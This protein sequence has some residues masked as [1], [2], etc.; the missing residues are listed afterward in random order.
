VLDIHLEGRL[1]GVYSDDALGRS[2]RFTYDSAYT[3]D[4][5]ATPLSL[6]LPMSTQVHEGPAVSA[7]FRGLLPEGERLIALAREVG[8]HEANTLP[9]IAFIGRDTAGAIQVAPSGEAPT[10]DSHSIPIDDDELAM[11]LTSGS[12]AQLTPGHG[13]GEVR[14]SLAGY[15]EK[16]ALTRLVDGTW[17]RPQ[18]TAASTHILKPSSERYPTLIADEAASLRAAQMLGLSTVQASLESTTA[19]IT[20]L[21]ITRYDRVRDDTGFVRRLHQEDLCQ[22]TGTPPELKGG[23][24]GGL[25]LED[26]ARSLDSSVDRATARAIK[27]DLVKAHMVNCGIGA[28]DAHAKNFSVLLRGPSVTLAPLYDVISTL[29]VQAQIDP[30]VMPTSMVPINGER[31]FTHLRRQDWVELGAALGIS[32]RDIDQWIEEL[33]LPAP[34][35]LLSAAAEVMQTPVADAEYLDRWHGLL[36]RYLGSADRRSLLAAASM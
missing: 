17:A 36:T 16:L 20:Y 22:A 18:G 2:A 9:L 10:Q 6:S 19:G 24:R 30:T 7:F 1:A 25:T 29:A 23:G 31:R 21:S 11:L 26:I 28:N 27:R 33:L 3:A 8:V 4:P 5:T 32:S 34:K 35:A 14:F 15:Q 13:S 12:A